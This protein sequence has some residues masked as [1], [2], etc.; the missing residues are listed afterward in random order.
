MTDAIV[1]QSNTTSPSDTSIGTDTTQG[2]VFATIERATHPESSPDSLVAACLSTSKL[3][4]YTRLFPA[5]AWLFV[6][7]RSTDKI[8]ELLSGVVRLSKT[9]SDG[10]RQIVDFV[11]PGEIFGSSGF[12]SGSG[13]T[14]FCS[15]DA[16]TSVQVAIYW[17]NNVDQLLCEMP[18]F[19]CAL[20]A[21]SSRNLFR[22]QQQML[23]LGRMSA[24]ERLAWFL[25][26]MAQ[27]Q[28]VT[29]DALLY[30]PMGRIDIADYL[31]LTVETV[32]RTFTQ[33]RQMRLIESEGAAAIRI[34][35]WRRIRGLADGK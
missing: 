4:V 20:V 21:A 14:A 8:Y 3:R 31:G 25:I 9:L 26:M 1:L 11:F 34:I 6:E 22:A 12:T 15:A 24:A 19:A 29:G 28:N 2:H 35:K 10:R 23:L 33:F 13:G 18:D 7:G 32:S 5:D 27:Q 16:V 30:L 17:Q